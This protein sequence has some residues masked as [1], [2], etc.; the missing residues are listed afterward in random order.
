MHEII[1]LSC[2]VDFCELLELFLLKVV[3]EPQSKAT[4]LFMNNRTKGPNVATRCFT[5]MPIE[6]KLN[7][8]CVCVA[9]VD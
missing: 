4:V 5:L 2:C 6:N 9:I 8:A 1:I 3:S 7:H